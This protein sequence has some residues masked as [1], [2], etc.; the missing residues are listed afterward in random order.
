MTLAT[1]HTPAFVRYLVGLFLT[2]VLFPCSSEGH[3][4]GETDG[5]NDLIGLP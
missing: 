5:T 1:P 3:G 4:G 2:V